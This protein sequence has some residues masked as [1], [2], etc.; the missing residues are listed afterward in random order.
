MDLRTHDVAVLRRVLWAAVYGEQHVP[1]RRDRRHLRDMRSRSFDQ[2]ERARFRAA[3]HRHAPSRPDR[4]EHSSAILHAP[5]RA[6]RGPMERPLR[7]ARRACDGSL[8][9]HA[10]GPYRVFKRVD[11][12]AVCAAENCGQVVL[13]GSEG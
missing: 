2:T 4:A 10:S 5:C 13:C 1:A 12:S 11:G 6:R 8:A 3:A 7:L 9:N